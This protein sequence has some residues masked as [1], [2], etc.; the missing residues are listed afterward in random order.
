[1]LPE[2]S[3]RSLVV[4]RGVDPAALVL[5]AALAGAYLVGVRRLAGR[6]RRWSRWRTGA[7]AAGIAAL[8]A[9]TQS[10]LAAYDTTLFSAH[11]VQHVLLGMVAPTLLALGAPVTLALQASSRPLQQVLVEVLHSAPARLV[12]HPVVVWVL[13]GG[14]L[15]ALY[16][17]PLLE[18]SLRNDVV[19]GLVHA[20]FVAAGVLFCWTA[21]GTD[22]NPH[23]LPHGAR[24][25]FVF[26]AV[27]V[28]AI[29]GLTLLGTTSLVAGGAYA[30]APPPWLD[31]VLGDQRLGAG[32]L[33]ATGEIFGLLLTG[34][35]LA[36]WMGA[37]EREGR[38]ADARLD[39][40]RHPR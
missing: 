7:F 8:V 29:V 16:A 18:A 3:L 38:R 5:C 37:E 20:H 36:R 31:D 33:W 14:T 22:P 13:F 26:L 21:V 4:P 15:V 27:P 9:A 10:G 24:V 28:H 32:I 30:E 17:G 40:G 34:I 39:A 19:H 1:V 35:A 11:T 12:A 23:R 25:G 6:G 2:P